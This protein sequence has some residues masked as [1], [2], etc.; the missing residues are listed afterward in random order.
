MLN[1]PMASLAS[2][3]HAYAWMSRLVG[4]WGA[5]AR[6]F[7]GNLGQSR[8][9]IE[10]YPAAGLSETAVAALCCRRG[11]RPIWSG[12]RGLCCITCEIRVCGKLRGELGGVR[13]VRGILLLR[14]LRVVERRHRKRLLVRLL[15]DGRHS[16]HRV[17]HRIL[18]RWL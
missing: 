18:R 8:S 2:W 16:R 7:L 3:V 5:D 13:L 17:R 9:P 14:E 4:S 12:R 10:Q 6:I 11:L 1:A 15:V